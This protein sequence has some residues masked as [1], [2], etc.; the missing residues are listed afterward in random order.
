M[1]VG[2]SDEG[3]EA[4]C[5]TAGEFRWTC[6][7]ISVGQSNERIARVEGRGLIVGNR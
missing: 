2:P 1:H 4:V 7:G 5:A 6:W 3:I